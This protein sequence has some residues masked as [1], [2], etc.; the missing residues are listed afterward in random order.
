MLIIDEPLESRVDVVVEDYVV[1]LGKRFVSAFGARGR[2]QHI[3]K[4]SGDIRRI[5]KRLGGERAERILKAF[6]QACAEQDK[7]GDLSSHRH[8]I[9]ILLDEYYDPMYRYQMEKRQGQTLY[10]G[11][12]AEVLACASSTERRPV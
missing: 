12:R 2:A 3:E 7:T 11:S 8:W 5:S 6:E 9:E 1:D 10:Q 4:L